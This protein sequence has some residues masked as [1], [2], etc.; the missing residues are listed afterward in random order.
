M[1]MGVWVV[2]VRA[3]FGAE[4]VRKPSDTR[5]FG[6]LASPD[7]MRTIGPLII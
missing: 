1:L 7:Y 4:F 2:Y 5:F 6:Q 3:G